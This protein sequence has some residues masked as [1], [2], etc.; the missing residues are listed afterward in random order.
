MTDAPDPNETS[1]QR[2]VRLKKE[3]IAAR[4]KDRPGG[5][6]GLKASAGMAA[7]KSK[8]WMGK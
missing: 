6:S 2:A 3:A 1:L 7:G 4:P 8:P 5:K